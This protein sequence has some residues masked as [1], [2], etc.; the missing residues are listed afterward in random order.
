ML[1]SFFRSSKPVHFIITFLMV[2]FTL[3]YVVIDHPSL[4]YKDLWIPVAAALS[5]ALFHFIAMKN[6][7][8]SN[9]S[10]GIWIYSCLLIIIITYSSSIQSFIAYL[11]LLFALRRVLSMRTGNQMTRKIFDASLWI[12]VAC[13]FY[14]WSIVFFA[15]V[16]LS[17]IIHAFKNLKFWVIP[18]IAVTTVIV[19][20]HTIDLYFNTTI[21]AYFFNGFNYNVDGSRVQFTSAF[22]LFF[23]FT[24]LCLIASIAMLLGIPSISLSARSRFSVLGFTGVC[25]VIE[26]VLNGTILLSIP[27]ISVF[28]TRLLQEYEHKGFRESILW[29]PFLLMIGLILFK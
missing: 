10:Y 22:I 28:F 8:I 14:S 24:L 1:S 11:F 16:F 20:T 6:E 27:V 21:W 3:G 19:I 18:L 29:I 23:S 2:I 12:A 15:I 9:N 13:A 5:V 17:I 4:D 25:V 7:F 26:F